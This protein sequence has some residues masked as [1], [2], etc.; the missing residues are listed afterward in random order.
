VFDDA[1][2]ATAMAAVVRP[3]NEQN[4]TRLAAE[5]QRLRKA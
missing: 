5:V 4:L 2:H 3:A 1:A